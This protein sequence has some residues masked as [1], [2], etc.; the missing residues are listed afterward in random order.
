[1]LFT[2]DPVERVSVFYSWN[3]TVTDLNDV[4][5]YFIYY[6]KNP[7]MQEYML[8]NKISKTRK[9]EFTALPTKPDAN[10]L[11]KAE[12]VDLNKKEGKPS[13]T[14]EY[15]RVVNLLVSLSAVLFVLCV[16][17]GAGLVQ[18][19]NRIAKLERNLLVLDSAYT[20]L[21]SSIKDAADSLAAVQTAFSASQST[22]AD[23]N[24]GSGLVL[25]VVRDPFDDIDEWLNAVL[26][27]DQTV[28]SNQTPPVTSSTE[29]V[30]AE[31]GDTAN[32]NPAPMDVTSILDEH[33]IFDTYVVQRGDSL[34][35]IS[36]HF[37]G[38]TE[39]VAAIMALNEIEDP[40]RIFFGKVLLLPRR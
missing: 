38:T 18:S 5:G 4:K 8:D 20:Y 28:A 15:R 17:I 13:V 19:D 34:N 36:L 37:Y 6:D 26:N 21:Q 39:M 32:E 2:I 7:G 10:R 11:A 9:P 25:D 3:D 31:N 14:R 35:A 16:V 1:V 22:S 33:D 24:E 30:P 29:E 27:A 23:A 40:D 12:L